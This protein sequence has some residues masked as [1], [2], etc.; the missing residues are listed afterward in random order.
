[1]VTIHCEGAVIEVGMKTP[2]CQDYCENL[3]FSIGIL[4]SVSAGGFEALALA[5]CICLNG[6]VLGMVVIL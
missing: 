1:M 5:G 2:T 3:P 4:D 6:E